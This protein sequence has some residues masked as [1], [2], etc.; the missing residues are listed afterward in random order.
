MFE[1]PIVVETR[2]VREA[3]AA[4]WGY[5]LAKIVSDLQSRQGQ[6]GRPVVDRTS[7]RTLRNRE[8]THSEGTHEEVEVSSSSVG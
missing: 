2:K 4:S 8:T 7:P 3:Y 5:D 1:D 6:D